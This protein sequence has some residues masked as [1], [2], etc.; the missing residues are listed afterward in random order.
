MY[1]HI[2][3]N[4]NIQ[5]FN[6]IFILHP[7]PLKNKIIIINQSILLGFTYQ[8]QYKIKSAKKIVQNKNLLNLIC[9]LLL[10]TTPNRTTSATIIN[11]PHPNAN[12]IEL[13][14]AYGNY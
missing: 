9:Q 13:R 8:K 1:V 11:F 3:L 4:K 2:Y 7:P 14:R 10:F 5:S 6:L 12:L